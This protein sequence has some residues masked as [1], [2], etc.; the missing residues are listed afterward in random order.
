M[1]KFTLTTRILLA[2]G[3]GLLLGIILYP[4]REVPFIDNYVLGFFFTLTGKLF[5]SSIKMMVVP[6]VFVSL[7][8]GSA[9]MGDV[10]KLGRIGTKTLV[11]YLL[12][13]AVAITIAI[14]LAS[15]V[16][17]G[18]GF[19][20]P[21]EEL[22]FVAKDKPQLLN[23]IINMVPTN[24][25][26]A[27]S[28]GNMLQIIVFS[29]LL[30]T[31]LT[32]LG[33][34]AQKV[35]DLFTQLNEVVLKLVEMVMTVAPIGVFALITK[36]FA[37]LGYS[38]MLPLLKYM[39]CIMG[40]LLLH[41]LIT[42]QSVFVLFTKLSPVKFIKNFAPA[43]ATAFSTSSSNAT[44][45]VTIETCEERLGVSKKLASFTLPLGA[46]INMDGT[47]IMQGVATVFI[48]QAYMIDLSIADFLTVIITATLASIGT[49]GV[50]GVGLIMLSMVLTQVG[51]PVEA[52]AIIMGIDRILDMS[53][54]A[55]NICGDAI[56]TTI[57]AK[58][59]G[60]LDESIFKAKN[61]SF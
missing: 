53:R 15:I 60:E 52:I 61:H 38:A 1:K 7:T 41:A 36:T 8:C 22:T 2:L 58:Q 26:K 44:L 57:I 48:A 37:S 24:P 30:G 39:L 29:I 9:S 35:T 50:P 31:S 32:I 46:T 55:I 49:A 45:P 54:T 19:N 56:C 33:E 40:A 42:Y 17:P 20:V 4:F 13:T 51:L 59:E 11:F 6:L 12:T 10:R 18:V 47:A 34:K 5:V 14:I 3:I 25:F 21:S 28:S 43:I 16:G 27:L 23:V